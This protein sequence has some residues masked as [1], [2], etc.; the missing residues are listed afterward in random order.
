MYYLNIWDD[1]AEYNSTYAYFEQDENCTHTDLK[2]CLEY[3]MNYFK[4]VCSKTE[5]SIDYHNLHIDFKCPSYEEIEMLVEASAYLMFNG[6]PV[7][8]YSES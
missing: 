1:F 7:H 2:D 8:V 3:V 6:I 5:M 4:S